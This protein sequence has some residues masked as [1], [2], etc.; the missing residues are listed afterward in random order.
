MTISLLTI[1]RNRKWVFPF[2][3]EN[4]KRVESFIDEWI[5]IDDGFE[6]LTDLVPHNPKIRYIRLTDIDDIIDN[7]PEMST[8]WYQFHKDIHRLPIG[9]KRNIGVEHCKGDIIVMMDDDDY[10]PAETINERVKYLNDTCSCVYLNVINVWNMR[11]QQMYECGDDASVSEATLAFK[12][13][14]WEE[15]GFKDDDICNEGVGF[16]KNRSGV[17]CITSSNVLTCIVHGHNVSHKK[18][19]KTLDSFFNVELFNP[20]QYSKHFL[21]IMEFFGYAKRGTYYGNHPL[22]DEFKRWGWIKVTEGP[23]DV[24]FLTDVIHSMPQVIV[25]GDVNLRVQS[26][27]QYIQDDLCC[28]KLQKCN[29]CPIRTS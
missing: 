3:L 14:F 12:K 15:Q 10:Y 6:D 27:N 20:P 4:F 26:Y 1:T 9:K 13:S 11:T 7:V 2:A 17:Q 18:N 29:T 22:E 8:V 16:V 25:T 23:I 24:L 28:H 19:K 5:I 21:W